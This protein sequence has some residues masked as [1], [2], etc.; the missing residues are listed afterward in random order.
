MTVGYIPFMNSSEI[1]IE[2]FRRFVKY[3]I[4]PSSEYDGSLV[5]EPPV[6]YF[7]ANRLIPFAGY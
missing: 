3:D 7:K 6:E 4:M 2:D 1:N 5:L